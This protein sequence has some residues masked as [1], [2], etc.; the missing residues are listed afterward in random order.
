MASDV[1]RRIRRRREALGITRAELAHRSGLSEDAL[2]LVER[3]TCLPRVENLLRLSDALRVAPASLLEG[4]PRAAGRA[5]IA[6]DRLLSYLG[7]R[8]EAD[9]QM[10]H[11]VARGVLER[12]RKRE[13]WRR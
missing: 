6:L 1:G 11:D 7:D 10:V 13:R 8:S 12:K 4:A 2:G 9:I 3:G 5:S